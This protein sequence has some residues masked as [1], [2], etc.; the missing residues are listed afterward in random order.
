[1]RSMHVAVVRGLLL[2]ALGPLAVAGCFSPSSG[3]ATDQPGTPDGS[4]D[5][6]A[7]AHGG[8]TVDGSA[9]NDAAATA[10][11]TTQTEA[12]AADAATTQTEAGSDAAATDAG[13]DAAVVPD[14]DAGAGCLSPGAQGTLSA[15]AEGLPA[16]G[17]ALWVRADRGVYKT[18]T[19]DVCAW[20]DQSN[21]GRLLTP[22][23]ARAQWQSASVGG[24]AAIHFAAVGT[25]LGTGSVLG[26]DPAGARTFVAVDQL[27]I[28]N[29]RFHPILQGNSS[30]SNQT[31]F[32][33]IDANTWQTAGY[34]EGAYI[35]GSSFD[36]A[37]ATTTSA[38]RVHVMTLSTLASGTTITTAV[39][40][41][42]NGVAQPLSITA[43]SGSMIDFSSANFTTI[44]AVSGTPTTTYGDAMVAEALIYDHAL[45]LSERQ[46]VESALEARYGIAADAGGP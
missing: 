5:D 3:D 16:A 23:T 36:T 44:G 13:S 43:G 42:V 46:A 7:T 4:L 40:Y 21:S 31:V 11:A 29:G 30:P 22:G 8:D 20:R 41:R 45:T 38:P 33:G 17:I 6:A 39:D 9:A 26:L 2:G 12:G 27:V 15:T 37:L 25:D 14:I 35:S 32:L 19:N 1:M 28:A 18:T 34:R 24:Q 10:D